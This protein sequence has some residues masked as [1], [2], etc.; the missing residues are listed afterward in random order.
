VWGR[1]TWKFVV[2]DDANLRYVTNFDAARCV[3]FT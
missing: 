2:G 1:G 3:Y